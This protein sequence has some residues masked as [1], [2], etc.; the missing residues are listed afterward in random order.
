MPNS[1]HGQLVGRIPNF[2]EIAS[3]AFAY[4]KLYGEKDMFSVIFT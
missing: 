1:D 3:E 4:I 2:V